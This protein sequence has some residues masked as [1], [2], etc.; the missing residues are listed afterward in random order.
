ML[1]NNLKETLAPA[2]IPLSLIPYIVAEPPSNF[3]YGFSGPNFM[4]YRQYKDIKEM[5]HFTSCHFGQRKLLLGEIMFL[6]LCGSKNHTKIIYAGAAPCDHIY[7]LTE[8]FPNYHFDLVDPAG[9]NPY[10]VKKFPSLANENNVTSCNPVNIN[11]NISVHHCF[12]TEELATSLAEKYKNDNVIFISDIRDLYVDSKSK[13]IFDREAIVNDNMKQQS[14][15]F[16]IIQSANHNPENVWCMLKFKPTF[17]T[18]MTTYLDGTLYYQ[19]WAPLQS[20]ELRLITNTSKTRQY[21]SKWLEAHLSWY[22]EIQRNTTVPPKSKL[23]NTSWDVQ[24]E[25]DLC[26]AYLQKTKSQPTDKDVVDMLWYISKQ[27]GKFGGYNSTL[28]KNV[29]QPGYQVEKWKSDKW[30]Q[31]IVEKTKKYAQ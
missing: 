4:P 1:S 19:G 20:P 29:F 18:E 31:R 24:Y 9:W 7:I 28:R 16:T 12:F 23:I 26:E 6:S 3:V 11:K 25:Y 22:N 21:N 8:L 10:F 14:N 27:L 2:S 13:D 30:K 15:W 5:N 17:E